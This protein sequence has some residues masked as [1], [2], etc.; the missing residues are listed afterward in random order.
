MSNLTKS[1]L[2]LAVETE[3]QRQVARLDEPRT[4]I[5]HEMLTY[6]MGWTG[7]VGNK[8]PTGKRI[9]PFI[10]LLVTAA[11]GHEWMPSVP[12]AAAVE[13]VH[14]FSLIHD[15][16]EDN[17]TERRGRLSVLKTCSAAIAASASRRFTA[18]PAGLP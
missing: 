10:L 9:R 11:A 13:I 16:I 18:C 4:K 17:S 2:F 5:Y 12:A 15:D 1:E 14:N 7:A 6:H 3:L 8:Q